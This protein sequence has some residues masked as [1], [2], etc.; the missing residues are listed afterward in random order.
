M[1]G[2]SNTGAHV[3]EVIGVAEGRNSGRDADVLA[4]WRRC[5]NDHRLDP[6]RPSAPRIVTQRELTQHRQEF[7]GTAERR[8]PRHG[9]PVSSS[10]RHGLCAA[11]GQWPGRHGGFHRRCPAGPRIAPCRA[12]LRL[13]MGRKPCR[14]Q[15]RRCLPG[16]RPGDH[17]ASQ[18]PFRR[19]ADA[20]VLHRRAD[21]RQH[22]Q[23]AGCSGP[24]ASAGARGQDEP[25]PDAGGDEILRPADRD[26][27]PGAPPPRRLD[28]AAAPVARVPGRG[29]DGGAGHRR[30][31]AH[32]RHDE[33]CA[34]AGRAGPALD[35]A[36]HR[37]GV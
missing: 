37:R 12:D 15:R 19:R 6:A 36:P 34:A 13:G 20:A 24:V 5:V 35:R 28:P 21:P 14:D 27:E 25:G 26:G 2:I 8:P 3:L 9:G 17:R 30:G 29:P 4:S 22:R 23:P 11:P 32:L 7:R 1:A 18:R 16:H 31:R 33:Q 10:E